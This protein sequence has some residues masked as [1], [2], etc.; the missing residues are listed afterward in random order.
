MSVVS[1]YISDAKGGNIEHS[2]IWKCIFYLISMLQDKQIWTVWTWMKV[3]RI[4]LEFRI[5]RLTFHGK[6]ASKCWTREIIIASLLSFQITKRQSFK[7]EIICFCRHLASFKIW[8]SKVQD[9]ENFELSPMYEC[10]YCLTMSE[11]HCKNRIIWRI[12]HESSWFIEFIKWV[13]EKR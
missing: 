3:F 1:V 11:Q 2:P 8:N 5:L 9:F 4:N 12:L 6:S 7:L 13:E 10:N